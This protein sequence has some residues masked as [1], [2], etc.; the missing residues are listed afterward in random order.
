MYCQYPASC[1]YVWFSE[2]LLCCDV[3]MVLAVVWSTLRVSIRAI[4]IFSHDLVWLTERKP[5]TTRINLINHRILICCCLPSEPSALLTQ[6]RKLHLSL[7]PQ[8][9]HLE[10]GEI[11][12]YHETKQLD[13][14][15]RN[16]VLH[17]TTSLSRGWRQRKHH[18]VC[19]IRKVGGAVL[20]GALWQ[21]R[22]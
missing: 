2:R 1:F 5:E 21:D 18:I 3:G 20:A 8:Q 6:S 10:S 17:V 12:K 15:W 9:Q 7:Q 13:E 4:S 16:H 11:N 19:T 22:K 14:T